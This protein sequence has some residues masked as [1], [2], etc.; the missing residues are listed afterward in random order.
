MPYLI[1]YVGSIVGFGTN[2]TGFVL[3]NYAKLGEVFSAKV[4][5]KNMTFIAHPKAYD[6]FFKAHD[7]ELEQREVY[8]FMKPVFGSGVVYDAETPEVMMEQLKFVTSG[9]TTTRFRQFIDIFDDEVKRKCAKLGDS[10]EID[11]F[12][13]LSDLIIFTASRC[14]LG[15]DIRFFLETKDLAKLY[16]DLD[17]G[18]SPLSFFYPQLPQSKRDTAKNRISAIFKEL[19]GIRRNQPDK[20]YDDVLDNLMHN[21]YKSGKPVPDDHIVGILIGGLFAGQHTSSISSTWTILNILNDKSLYKRVV[22]EQRDIMVDMDAN[23]E[24]DKVMSMD[25]L[26]RCLQEALRMYPPL[27]MLMRYVRKSRKYN[28]MVIPKGNILV[29]STAAGGRCPEVFE[30]PDVFDPERFADPRREHEKVRHGYLAF[31]SG[32][33]KCIGENFA[34][35]QIKSVLSGL[36]RHY[37]LELVGELPKVTYNSLVVGPSPPCKIRYTRR[38]N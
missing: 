30:N 16:H 28:D 20:R 33:H 29:V 34:I 21:E 25:L 35:L 18:I 6:V 38:Q 10:G 26:E 5:G 23:L 15:D 13:H 2:P 32:R 14:L 9:L 22:Q 17:E 8:K 31:G 27:I 36:L 7:T 37:D 11:I 4:L 19:I 12:E 3:D 24:Y 1:P